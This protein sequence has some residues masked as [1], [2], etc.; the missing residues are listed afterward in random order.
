MSEKIKPAT[1]ADPA[2]VQ[3]RTNGMRSPISSTRFI[4]R[5]NPRVLTS[6]VT[7][8]FIGICGK[9]P[10][11]QS[12]SNAGAALDSSDRRRRVGVMESIQEHGAP[13]G[14]STIVFS[15]TLREAWRINK[16]VWAVADGHDS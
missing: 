10:N 1:V 14:G 16:G 3:S 8:A 2:H 15:P 13:A 9:A 11:D 6:V 5:T 12:E 7:I 4:R